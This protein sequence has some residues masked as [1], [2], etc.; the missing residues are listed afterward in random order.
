MDLQLSGRVALVTGGSRG[1]GRAIARTLAAEGAQVAFCARHADAV[2]ATAESLSRDTGR[3]VLGFVAD[4]GSRDGVVELVQSVTARLGPVQILVNNAATAAGRAKPPALA[5]IGREALL[6]E[7]DVKVLGYLFAAQ[8]VAAEMRAA[9]WGRIINIAGLASRSTGSTIGTI[10]NVSVAAITKNL[11]DEL[12]PDGIT[13]NCV[14]PGLTRTV[15][16]AEVDPADTAAA[17]QAALIE[18]RIPRSNSIRRMID[19][20]DIAPVVAFLASPLSFVINGEMIDTG[21]G[22]P[23]T[24]RY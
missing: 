18:E 19:D 23:G 1:I 8:A 17:A 15:R 21:G 9:G 4:T 3:E 12:G 11:A 5:E 10:R 14:H 13:V 16:S 6:A 7:I 24:I 20:T 22:V 2:T